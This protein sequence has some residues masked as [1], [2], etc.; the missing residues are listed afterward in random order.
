VLFFK[1]LSF[2]DYFFISIFFFLLWLVIEVHKSDYSKVKAIKFKLASFLAVIVLLLN[3]AN[4]YSVIKNS[5]TTIG[6]THN[7]YGDR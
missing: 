4:I 5:P 3:V 2:S 6:R 7:S 1:A